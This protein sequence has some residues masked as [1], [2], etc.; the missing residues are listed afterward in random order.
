MKQQLT[1]Q[2][3]KTYDSLVKKSNDEGRMPNIKSIHDL[4]VEANIKHEYRDTQ[5]IVESQSNG[6][7]YLNSRRDGKT[8]KSIHVGSIYMDSSDSYYS[9]NSWNYAQKLVTLLNL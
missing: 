6:N 1:T 3:K 9:V 8:G 4:L 2:S 5:N 7:I